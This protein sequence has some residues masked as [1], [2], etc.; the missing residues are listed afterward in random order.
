MMPLSFILRREGLGFKLGPDGKLINHLLFMDDLKL[1]GRSEGQ[2]DSLVRIVRT[3]SQDIGMQFGID[4]CAVLTVKK[5]VKVRCEGIELPSGEVMKEVD[6]TGYKYL[7]VLEG[8][9]IKNREMKGKIRGEYLRRVKALAKSKLYAGNLLRGVNAW[10][11]GVVRYS[12]GIVEWSDRELKELD[13]KTRKILAMQGVFR[14]KS[15]VD[16]LYLKRRDGGRGLISVSDCVREEERSLWEY[17]R[18]SKEWMLKV[19][20]EGLVEGETKWDYRNRIE[21]ERK[22]RL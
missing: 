20:G 5:G 21:E 15:S 13:T 11:I 22:A 3:Y 19:V 2:L 16:R 14:S 4:K 9:D 6:E 17:V 8:A 18:C 1:Y 7:G 10:A 12:A